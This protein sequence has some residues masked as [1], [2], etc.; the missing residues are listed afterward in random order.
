M[1][2]NVSLDVNVYSELTILYQRLEEELMQINPGCNECGI[3]CDFSKFDHVLYAS[4]IE[5][6]FITQHI[7]VPDFN[8][9][10]NICPFLKNNQC[11]IRNFRMLGCRVFYCNPHYQG[12]SQDVYEK[13]HH[14]IK[15]LST[16]YNIT[17]EY[18]SFLNQLAKFKSDTLVSTH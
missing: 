4:S 5:V 11:S 1:E 17:W 10:D 12:I 16:K 2:T 13:Y 14:R 7:K 9:L 15:E 3:C 8:V 18:K 6:N